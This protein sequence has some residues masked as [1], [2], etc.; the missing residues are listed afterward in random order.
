MNRYLNK[1]PAWNLSKLPLY[2]LDRVLLHPPEN[3]NA[4][5]EELEWLLDTMIDGLKTKEVCS[6]VYLARVKAYLTLDN[7][8]MGHYRRCGV[9]ERFL[10]LYSSPHLP[11]VLRKKIIR[12]VYRATYVDG[13]TTLL[14]RAGILSWTQVQIALKDSNTVIFK[15]LLERLIETCDHNRI[16]VWSGGTISDAARSIT[17]FL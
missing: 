9:Y 6:T 14:T 5:E 2:W 10:S 1:G 3:D 17:T 8:D 15:L 16:G 7:Q 4:H 12:L 11:S 13:S